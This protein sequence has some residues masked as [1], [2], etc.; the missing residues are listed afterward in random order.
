MPG[1]SA[2]A[3]CIPRY[4]LPREVIA[5]HWGTRPLPGERSVAGFDEDA[6]T[7]AVDASLC[8][9]AGPMAAELDGV[10]FASTTSP[11][12]E[13]LV[14][15]TLATVLALPSTVR[16]LDFGDSLRAASNALFTAFDLIAA[17]RNRRLLVAAGELRPATPDSHDEQAAGDAG[18]AVV[19]SEEPGGVELIARKSVSEELYGSWRTDTQSYPQ[20]FPGSLDAKFGYGRVM[21]QVIQAVLDDAKLG[22]EDISRAVICG[23]NPRAVMGVARALGI[24]PVAQLQDTLWTAVGNTGAAQALLLLAAALERAHPGD[25]ILWAVYGDGADAAVFRVGERIA[26][27]RPVRGIEVQLEVKR[28]LRAYGKYARWRG[29]VKRDYMSM[30]SS[31]AAILYR[32]RKAMLPLFGGRCPECG[33]L[34]FPINR[35][36]VSCAHA[37]GL[38]EEALPR[39]GKVFTF[40]HNHV[41][42]HPDPPLMEAV[43]E[44]EGGVRF[45]AHLTDVDPGDVAIDMPVEL[46]FRLHHDA[47][48][49]HNYFWKARPI[50]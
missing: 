26:V 47:A 49:L 13:K 29:L 5:A 2:F 43:L 36:C 3:T 44:L 39:T 38:E 25:L 32:D 42:P 12:Q 50:R 15:T 48:G 9:L 6:L 1:I 23:A 14:A 16:T 8:A 41:V 46:V 33:T 18:A 22:V 27:Q 34:Q 40:Y 19:V 28:P 4:R 17:G 20:S 30:E 21:P 24:D 11:Y 45:F 37:G 10:L 31:S 35:V 7:L